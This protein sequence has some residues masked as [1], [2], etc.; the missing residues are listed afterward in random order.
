M[1]SLYDDIY[2]LMQ[3]CAKQV[4][5]FGEGL[6]TV[7]TEPIAVLPRQKLKNV[8]YKRNDGISRIGD[9]ITNF[10]KND[11][12]PIGTLVTKKGVINTPRYLVLNEHIMNTYGMIE[13]FEED[14]YVDVYFLNSVWYDKITKTSVLS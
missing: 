3:Y 6:T 11:G 8:Y 7:Q 4:R 10:T 9:I 12:E 14:V 13:T 1:H 2:L 5:T